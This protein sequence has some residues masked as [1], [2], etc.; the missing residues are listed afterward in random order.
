MKI[1]AMRRGKKIERLVREERAGQRRDPTPFYLLSDPK[2]GQTGSHPLLFLNLYRRP[3][4]IWSHSD[5]GSTPSEIHII[6]GI[7]P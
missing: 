3:Q 1:S 2:I 5:I 4:T 7:G 6:A